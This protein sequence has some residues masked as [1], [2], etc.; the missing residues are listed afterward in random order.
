MLQSANVFYVCATVPSSKTKTDFPLCQLTDQPHEQKSNDLGWYHGDTDKNLV[1]LN[2][3]SYSNSANLCCIPA[4]GQIL[5]W[6]LGKTK[7][8]K[9]VPQRS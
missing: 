2:F 6:I 9:A 1:P 7:R 8:N 3:N 4:M 5:D